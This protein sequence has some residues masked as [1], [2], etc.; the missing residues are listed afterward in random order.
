MRQP[1][2]KPTANEHA[3]TA[4][5]ATLCSSSSLCYHTHG[6]IDR[7]ACHTVLEL[8]GVLPHIIAHMDG[9]SL[10]ALH[11]T[12]RELHNSAAIIGSVDCV[13]RKLGGVLCPEEIAF[14]HR[15]PNLNT[16]CLDYPATLWPLHALSSMQLTVMAISR[17]ESHLVSQGCKHHS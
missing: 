9:K 13:R 2:C 7:A 11:C 1:S 3:L 15:L 14:L 4:L 6:S 12:C 17:P 16:L 5:L 10:Q 8:E